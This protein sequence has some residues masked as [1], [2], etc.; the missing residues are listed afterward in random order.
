MA[1]YD[2]RLSLKVFMYGKSADFM[3]NSGERGLFTSRGCCKCEAWFMKLWFTTASG[4]QQSRCGEIGSPEGEKMATYDYQ[5][6][7]K[8][9]M[10]GKSADFMNNSGYLNPT[11]V[12]FFANPTFVG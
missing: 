5:L 7:L 1:T 10:Y 2:Y 3:N 9:F 4:P 8:V 11:K 6:F 12:V